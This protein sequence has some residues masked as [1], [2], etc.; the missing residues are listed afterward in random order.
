LISEL[1]DEYKE[2]DDHR[3]EILVNEFINR[4]WKSN[5]T[6]KTYKK[7]YTYIVKDDLLDNRIDLIDLFN[8]YITAIISYKNAQRRFWELH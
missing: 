4:L 3:K 7:Y 8:K 2:I 5:Y 6:Y 1:L